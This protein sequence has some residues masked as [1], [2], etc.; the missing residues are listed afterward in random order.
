MR[1]RQSFTDFIF[2]TN[3]DGS[4]KAVSYVRALDM[5]R[6]IP[7]K[8]YK[9]TQCKA[10]VAVNSAMLEFY[11]NLCKDISE[12]Y[13]GK[14]RDTGS[15]QKLSDVLRNWLLTDLYEREG[16]GQTD[17]ARRVRISSSTCM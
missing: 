15:F 13:P 14:V 10:A 2:A 17:F 8:Q 5:F 11:W 6:P 7:T 1:L 9:A 3:T 16:K 4:G 12:K